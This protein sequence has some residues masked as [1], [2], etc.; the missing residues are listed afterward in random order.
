MTLNKV[1]AAGAAKALD[2]EANRNWM[3]LL[4]LRQGADQLDLARAQGRYLI[5]VGLRSR[6][7]NCLHFGIIDSCSKKVR[8][9]VVKVETC[10]KI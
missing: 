5:D 3:K 9:K 1:K 2:V 6:L 8:K 7:K 4:K 10:D